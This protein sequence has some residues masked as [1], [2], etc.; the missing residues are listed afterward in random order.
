M[1]KERGILTFPSP[2]Q[3][4]ICPAPRLTRLIQPFAAKTLHT[5]NAGATDPRPRRTHCTS[6]CRETKC[7][8]CVKPHLG[9]PDLPAISSNRQSCGGLLF[10]RWLDH[11]NNSRLLIV[12]CFPSRFTRK[13]NSAT[14]YSAAYHLPCDLYNVPALRLLHGRYPF[15][16]ASLASLVSPPQAAQSSSSLFDSAATFPPATNS[17]LRNLDVPLVAQVQGFN[18]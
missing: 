13:L 11:F 5:L 6:T 15:L 7:S 9:R 16:S 1:G 12:A 17:R 2:N 10:L 4:Y 3:K 8:G 18:R 14:S